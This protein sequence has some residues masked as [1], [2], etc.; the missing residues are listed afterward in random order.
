[1][2]VVR[3]IEGG[4]PVCVSHAAA[5]VSVRLKSAFFISHFFLSWQ[6]CGMHA[7]HSELHHHSN[8]ERQPHLTSFRSEGV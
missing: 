3:V 5:E 8:T 2:C 6:G 1:M 4:K 7:A